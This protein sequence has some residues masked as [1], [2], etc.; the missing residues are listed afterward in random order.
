VIIDFGTSTCFIE[1]RYIGSYDYMKHGMLNFMIP[2]YDMY[3]FLVNCALESKTVMKNKIRS[4]FRFYGDNDPY[5]INIY[6]QGLITSDKEYCKKVTFSEAATYTPLM[7]VEWLLK[8]Y[9]LESDILVS[10]RV[11]YLPI[12]Y[13]SLIKEYDKI[14]K[15]TNDGIE[16]VIESIK[17]CITSTSSYV[18]TKYNINLLERYNDNLQSDELSRKIKDMNKYLH[19]FEDKFIDIDK[20]MLENVF[21]IKIP[22]RKDLEMCLIKLLIIQIPNPSYNID[23]KTKLYIEDTIKELDVLLSYEYELIPYLQFYFTILELQLESKFFDWIKNFTKSDIYKFYSVNVLNTQRAKRWGQSLSAY[24]NENTIVESPI[25]QEKPREIKVLTYNVLHEIS[26]INVCKE[27]KCLKNICSFIDKNTKDF[28]F[29]GIQEY[30]NIPKMR[31]YSK[32]LTKMSVTHDEVPEY[33]KKYGPVTFYDNKK[34]KLDD[35]CNTMKF[36]FSGQLGRGIQINFF[37]NNLCIIN[38]HAGHAPKDKINMFDK[39]LKDYLESAFCDK[40]C[41]D[42]FIKKLQTYKIIMIGDMNNNLNNFTYITIADKERSLYGRTTKPTCCEEKKT[43]NG[44]NVEYDAYDH[45][46][47]TFAKEFTVKVYRPME[48]H[49]DHDPVSSTLTW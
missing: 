22:T 16:H 26:K 24:D 41:K 19:K 28:D 5:N 2:G 12:Q 48:L 17:K 13:S 3:K 49:S 25:F 34:Y 40:K 7:F 4:I 47:S 23:E 44:R 36:G 31:Q 35:S 14:F 11:H 18:M 8:E 30:S 37:N 29:I 46:L 27:D 10:N 32:E 1:N 15:Y 39:S 20:A 43:M 21:D 45:I 38:V 6:A 33:L 42:I 9:S